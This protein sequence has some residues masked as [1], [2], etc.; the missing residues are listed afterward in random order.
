MS[1]T[2]TPSD[3][4]MKTIS[5]NALYLPLA[6]ILTLLSIPEEPF[7]ILAILLMLDYLTGI[8]KVFVLKGHIRSYR[9]I[10][11]LLTKGSILV[12]VL[13]LALMAKG[14]ELDFKLYLSLFLS[15]LIISETYSIFGNVYS[16]INKEEIAEFDAVSMVIKRVR[17]VLER[18]LINSRDKL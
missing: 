9:A 7:Y 1:M 8:L 12:L 5:L 13:V 3:L 14:L 6:P 16:A 18:V 15:A 17:L 11:G 2:N 4:T 10:A